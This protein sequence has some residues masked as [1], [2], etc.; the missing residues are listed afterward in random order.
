MADDFE[1]SI[2]DEFEAE[3]AA[4]KSERSDGNEQFQDEAVCCCGKI[5]LAPIVD[6]IA[7]RYGISADIVNSSEELKKLIETRGGLW[8]SKQRIELCGKLA[9][10][11]INPSAFGMLWKILFGE[12]IAPD[13]RQFSKFY[14][15]IMLADEMLADDGERDV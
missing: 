1:Q 15:E 6:L 4:S 9:G 14:E 7:S 10:G 8:K 11:Q 2:I 12:E 13:Q 5:R 3:K